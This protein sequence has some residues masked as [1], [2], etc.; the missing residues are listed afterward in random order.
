[1]RFTIVP[2]GHTTMVQLLSKPRAREG[3]CAEGWKTPANGPLH[4]VP[5][6]LVPKVRKSTALL[7]SNVT[8]LAQRGHGFGPWSTQTY[9]ILREHTFVTSV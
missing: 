4:A 9:R 3:S 7:C 1:M 2:K 8:V 6:E 5:G